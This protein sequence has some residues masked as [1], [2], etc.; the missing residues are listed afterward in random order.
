MESLDRSRLKGLDR[1]LMLRKSES[2]SAEG[3]DLIFISHAT[4][5]KSVA[6]KIY[7]DLR[8]LGSRPW[9]AT[10]DMPPGANFAKSIH[11]L[12]KSASAVV[13]LLT[14]SSFKSEHVQREVS[15]AISMKKTLIPVNIS[16]KENIADELPADWQ[17]WLTIVQILLYKDS[18]TT[19]REIS[20]V[21]EMQAV[22]LNDD[23]EDKFN[24]ATVLEEQV[25]QPVKAET[26]VEKPATKPNHVADVAEDLVGNFDEIPSKSKMSE[27]QLQVLISKTS[28]STR[29]AIIVGLLVSIVLMVA[30]FKPN[31]EPQ[32]DLATFAE[33]SLEG[34]WTRGDFPKSKTGWYLEVKYASKDLYQGTWYLKKKKSEPV[35]KFTVE[36]TQPTTG[37]N[38]EIRWPEGKVSKGVVSPMPND[39]ET[40]PNSFQAELS[41]T[42]CVKVFEGA[43]TP[44]DCF[45]YLNQ[46]SGSN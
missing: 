34:T 6:E 21:I 20:K 46:I 42:N 36:I 28:R 23:T 13:V 12:L 15:L 39:L 40:N 27:G 19:A 35:S 30:I 16:S 8:K 11:D 5:D 43:K 2:D 17:Y 14:P 24:P 32:S 9:M 29:F 10:L 4:E 31:P 7:R 26:E 18:I 22:S 37:G 38:F 25:E 45:Y 44:I 33:L 3:G 1:L 41:M